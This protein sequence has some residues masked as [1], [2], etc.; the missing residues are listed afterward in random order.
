S[1]CKAVRAPSVRTALLVNTAY[2]G[3]VQETGASLRGC[4]T[5]PPSPSPRLRCHPCR[6]KTCHLAQDGACRLQKR[7]RQRCARAL[8]QAQAQVE[9]RLDSQLRQHQ[10]VAWLGGSV[11]EN[12]AL[13]HM[14][15]QACGDQHGGAGDEAI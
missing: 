13:Q 11:R 1:P 2:G 15:L 14:G 6:F 8:T 7:P 10:G 9:Q 12:A 4:L 5:T 3:G